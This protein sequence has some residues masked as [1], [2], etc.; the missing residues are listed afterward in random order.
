[1]PSGCDSPTSAASQPRHAP[2]G[3]LCPRSA[4]RLATWLGFALWVWMVVPGASVGLGAVSVISR[5]RQFII[6]SP[7][8]T[9]PSLS[10]VTP[11]STNTV[12]TLQPDPL[13]VSCE[14]IKAALL[15]ELG[16]P[17]RW[18]GKIHVTIERRLAPTPF[19]TAVAVRYADGWQYAL[20][21][22]REIEGRALVRGVV[23]AVLTEI[24][25]QHPGPGTA[26][27]PIWLVEALT[28]QV[29]ARVGPD[30]LARLN[31]VTGRYAVGVGQLQATLSERK[32]VDEQQALL[33]VLQ[34]RPLLTFEEISIPTPDKL[35][36]PGLVHY[37][38][39][40]RLLFT[41]LRGLPAG[42]QCFASMLAQ[43][44]SHLNWQ[45][46]FL[47]GFNRH[48]SRM[49][50]VEKWWALGAQRL[51]VDSR[52]LLLSPATGLLWLEDLLVVPADVQQTPG[53]ARERRVV[54]LETVVVEWNPPLQ[55]QI[56]ALRARQLRQLA[57]SL[58][59][60]T[61]TLAIGYAETL[62]G[63]LEAR[64]RARS[65]PGL[66]GMGNY[67]SANAVRAAAARLQALDTQRNEL[68]MRLNQTSVPSREPDAT[69]SPSDPATGLSPQP[70]TPPA[71][72]ASPR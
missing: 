11:L 52:Q 54:P 64:A 66:R 8:V 31:P 50:D 49:L 67:Q 10:E 53:V 41:S 14:R 51:R 5:S 62:Q 30:P 71:G 33:R 47:A 7:Q 68:R 34:S 24:A 27:I 45:T 20:H 9:T 19:P 17:D 37:E 25:N 69:P 12:L 32:P 65:Q 26:E 55:T 22:P 23:H 2:R 72:A 16:R 1:M 6:H 57:P 39:C 18:R 48:F 28:G 59:P 40:A 36:P 29:L 21:L 13:A 61:Q 4:H 42:P 46:A 58:P 15:A 63:F 43:L 60:E 70:E 56:L 3:A 38:A 44:P 35:E